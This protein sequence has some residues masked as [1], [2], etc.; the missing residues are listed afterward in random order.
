MWKKYGRAGQATDGNKAGRRKVVICLPDI[1]GNNTD[2]HL[3]HFVLII[4]VNSSA[5][6]FIPG[7][8]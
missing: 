8:Q 6:Y 3:K 1:K 7:E 4:V 5:K 2:K